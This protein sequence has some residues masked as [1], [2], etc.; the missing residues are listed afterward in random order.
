MKPLSSTVPLV[1]VV[2]GIWDYKVMTNSFYYTEPEVSITEDENFLRDLRN[3][4]NLNTFDAAKVALEIGDKVKAMCKMCAMI[5]ENKDLV[6]ARRAQC[7][8]P[9]RT[10]LEAQTSSE[11][12][13]LIE[14]FEQTFESFDE[15][16]GLPNTEIVSGD[17]AK[18]TVG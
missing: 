11:H 14:L 16:Q 2:F 12:K 15:C 18:G 13:T 5:A 10:L 17:L 1:A 9:V 6:N 4:K 7:I 8:P 3:Y